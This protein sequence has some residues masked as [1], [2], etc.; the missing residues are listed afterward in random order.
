MKKLSI[1][2]I[3]LLVIAGF[4]FGQEIGL[5]ASL[6]GSATMTFGVDLNTNATGFRNEATADLVVTV[7]AK[8]TGENAGSM[9]N[10]YGKIVIKDYL[11]KVSPVEG[12]TGSDGTV[13]AFIVISPA[14]VK[15]YAAPGF[16]MN[17]APAIESVNE[18][19]VQT[20]LSNVDGT[21]INGITI[22][23]PVD[24]ITLAIKVASDGDWTENVNNN[25]V[26]GADVTL[27]VSPIK[28]EA[29]FV[30]GWFSA[31]Q[32]GLSAKATLTLADIMNGLT[33]AVALDA[34]D[35]SGNF[36]IDTLTTVTL[37]FSEANGDD[38][39]ANLALSAFFAPLDPDADM[40]VQVVFTEPTAGGLADMVGA[41]VKLQL[42]D[43][44]AGAVEYNIDVT[45]EYNT[46]DVKPYFGFGYGTDEV[47]NLNLGVVLMAGLTG[48]DNTTI[49]IDYI[50]ADLTDPTL[51]N[52]VITVATKVAY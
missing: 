30:Y 28:V 13:E 45:G 24:P 15:I 14:T 1:L 27:N 7:V 16:A 46:G 34:N 25:Y 10:L 48:I 22:T 39:K 41:T 5:A 23:I 17:K 20:A 8:A 40:D 42:L 50:S 49:T 52:G 35:G 37:N 12:V 26:A 9:D 3:G 36:D 43:L 11:L 51:D 19:D 21:S 32:L 33:A 6:S 2:L 44:L 31:A 4:A 47:L 38:V 18:V 29:G